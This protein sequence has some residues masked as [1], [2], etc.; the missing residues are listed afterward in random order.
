MAGAWCLPKN[1]TSAFLD[2]VRDGTLAPEKLMAM[3]SEERRAEFA[4]ILGPENAKEVN[5]QFEQKM[6]L[7]DQKAGLVNWAKKIGGLTEPA[8]RDILNTINKLDRILNPEEQQAF[9]EDL[10]AKKLGVTVT[11]EEA[12]EVF[13]L[14]QKAEQ[15]RAE[16]NAAG[17]GDYRSGWTAQTGAEYGKAKMALLDK[18]DSLKPQG[19]TIAN[20]LLNVLSLPKSA[21][22]SVL[23]W[24]APFVQG[25]GMI[26]TRQWWSGLGQMFRYFADEVNYQEL[27]GYIIGHPDYGIARDAKLGLTHL[28]DKLSTREETIQ[29][30]LL[31]EAN[32]WLSEKT[33][34]P[35]L[36]RAWSRS[37][38]GFLNYVRFNRYTDLLSAA[39]L[40]GEDVSLGSQTA[41]D[42]AKVVNNFSGRGELGE[43]DRYAGIAPVLNAIFFSPRKIVA[44]V[45]MFNPV[46]YARL[47]P[48]AR[49]AA[50]RQLTGSLLATGTVLTLAK[51]MGA[52][53]NFDPRSSDFAK[54]DIGGEK[55]D[56]TGGNAS[57][58]RLLA[59]MATNQEI[60]STGK[61]INFGEDGPH[62]ATR[63]SV[64]TNYILGKLGPIPGLMADMLYGHN[65]A[66]QAFSVTDEAREKL[67]P[68][69]INSWLNFAMN[70]PD[71]TAAIIP[72]LSALLGVGLESP[73]PPM[74]ETGMD[75]WGQ[76]VPPFGTSASFR[77][78]PVNQAIKAINFVPKPAPNKI[79]GVPLTDTELQEYV[80]DSGVLAHSRLGDVIQSSVWTTLN[81]AGRVKLTQSIIRSSREIAA[82]KIMSANQGGQHDIMRISADAKLAAS[83]IAAAPQ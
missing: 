64:V 5:A 61:L 74:S 73:L 55:L 37:F 17:G 65:P 41:R 57:Y 4:K 72:A 1:L 53:V 9:L 76:P 47:S 50:I 23:H 77:H 2:A 36:I 34:V 7:K 81:D 26:S 31:E 13:D 10:A 71:D 44:T 46:A 56:M 21:L 19:G 69:V 16:I 67:F 63:A 62:G 59:R 12:K 51:V 70:N 14:A 60:T 8:R 79:R 38:T 32:E 52:N 30:S 15:L 54:I 35:N 78:D 45:E 48:V 6:L 20:K 22:T 68:I 28:S 25:W 66:G 83:G 27:E 33:G 39:R 49:N 3:T 82:A 11:A 80:H 18:I 29:S 43:A 42:L 24:S 58:V 75:A 40:T